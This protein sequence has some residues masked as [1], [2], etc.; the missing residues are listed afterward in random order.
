M[1]RAGRRLPVATP[2]PR[3]PYLTNRFCRD[4]LNV[5]DFRR[6]GRVVEMDLTN[7]VTYDRLRL[8]QWGTGQAGDPHV[9]RRQL[10]RLA[11]ASAAVT[12][13]GTALGGTAAAADTPPIVKPLPPELFTVYGSNAETRWEAMAGQ[14]YLTPIDRFFV[15]DHTATPTLDADTWRLRLSGSGLRGAPTAGPPVEFS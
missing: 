1:V 10:M 15:R 4:L 8:A 13:T 9:S 7:E 11:A 12:A 6:M 2:R 5:R 14:G 3:F